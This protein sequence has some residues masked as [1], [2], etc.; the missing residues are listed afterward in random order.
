MT[1][2]LAGTY[3]RGS[4]LAVD[5][6]DVS[7]LDGLMCSDSCLWLPVIRNRTKGRDE[8]ENYP[9]RSDTR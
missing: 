5:T 9:Q 1:K 7:L 4:A 6:Y 2:Y 8:S 3:V